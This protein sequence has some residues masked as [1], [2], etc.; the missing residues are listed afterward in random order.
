[1]VRMHLFNSVVAMCICLSALLSN[2]AGNDACSL[3]LKRS[4]SVRNVSM[5]VGKITA[6]PEEVPYYEE[7]FSPEADAAIQ[8]NFNW[9]KDLLF[10]HCEE[11]KR[12]QTINYREQVPLLANRMFEAFKHGI[13]LADANVDPNC[14]DFRG[15][16]L[17]HYA[18][19]YQNDYIVAALL[20]QRASVHVKNVSGYT[21]LHT[22]CAAGVTGIVSLLL[23]AGADVHAQNDAGKTPLHVAVE[24]DQSHVVASLLLKDDINLEIEDVAGQTPLFI[25]IRR[26]HLYNSIALIKRAANR[27]HRDIFGKNAFEIALDVRKLS[28]GKSFSDAL[29]AALSSGDAVATTNAQNSDSFEK[30]VV[31]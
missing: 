30:F 3:L 31:G 14:T 21:P 10:E 1:M 26:C 12:M 23:Q 18:V 11:V 7:C 27:E 9:L 15:C 6:G 4:K 13:T 24:N 19:M 28:D 25:A 22:A 17:L 20:A 16:S 2:S 29:N 5:L 8:N